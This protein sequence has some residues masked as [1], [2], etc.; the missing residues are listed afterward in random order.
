MYCRVLVEM[1]ISLGRKLSQVSWKLMIV[2]ATFALEQ[3]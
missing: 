2:K 1:S 3:M